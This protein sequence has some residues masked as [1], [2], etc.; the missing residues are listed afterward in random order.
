MKNSTNKT[1]LFIQEI[2]LVNILSYGLILR[3]LCMGHCE[4]NFAPILK[5]LKAF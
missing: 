5:L 1:C 3:F 4:N 2:I